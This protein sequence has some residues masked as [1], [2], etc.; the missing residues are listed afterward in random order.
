[1]QRKALKKNSQ[2]K[3]YSIFQNYSIF[4]CVFICYSK[5]DFI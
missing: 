4:V 1:M 2:K 5:K 3:R